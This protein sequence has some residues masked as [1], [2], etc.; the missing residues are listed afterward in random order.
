MVT[1]EGQVTSL[2]TPGCSRGWGMGEE[3][4]YPQLPVHTQK[5]QVDLN[6]NVNKI[7]GADKSAREE[8]IHSMRKLG[9]KIFLMI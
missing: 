4:V 6:I 1:L 8:S 9:G 7:P 3:S 5:M 2:H